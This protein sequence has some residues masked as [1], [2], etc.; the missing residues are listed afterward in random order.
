[1]KKLLFGLLLPFLAIV[2]IANAQETYPV[3]DLP[4]AELGPYLTEVTPPSSRDFTP[5]NCNDLSQD[6]SIVL[7]VA[8]PDPGSPERVGLQLGRIFRDGTASTCPFKV[9]PG[10]FNL[11]T[12]YGYHAIQF[13]NISPDPVCI[14]INVT[15]NGG[16]SP[17]ATNG[18]GLVYQSADGL[19]PAPYD[20]LNQSANYLGDL[21][22]S[23][24][25]PFSVTVNPGFFEVVFTNT[26]SV[27]QCDVA[28]NITVDPADAGKISCQSNPVPISNWAII[29]GVIAIAVFTLL[30]IKRGL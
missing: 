27:S 15:L 2:N 9:Y 12:Q 18:H 29:F 14:T 23:V 8:S 26:S 28:F 22:S 7:G 13:S 6:I 19:N 21:G 20:P 4:G 10:D 17:C 24:S 30:R 3:N 5:T 11:G 25:Q 16:A 1:M